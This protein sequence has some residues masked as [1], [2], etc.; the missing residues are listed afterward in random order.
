MRLIKQ[1][2]C[3]E[4][5]GADAN[6]GSILRCIMGHPSASVGVDGTSRPIY[7]SVFHCVRAGHRVPEHRPQEG[8]EH[9]LVTTFCGLPNIRNQ[10]K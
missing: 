7:P 5:S 4:A 9:E 3:S 1:G 6:L 10:H 2:A 8:G